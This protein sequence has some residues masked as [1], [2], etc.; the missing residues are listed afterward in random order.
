MYTKN[1]SKSLPSLNKLLMQ[2]WARQ[3]SMIGMMP[4]VSHSPYPRMIAHPSR[5]LSNR[6]GSTRISTTMTLR[7]MTT[8]T[9]KTTSP[10]IANTARRGTSMRIIII[11]VTG[12]LNH[13]FNS[14]KNSKQNKSKL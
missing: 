3:G 5:L 13:R 10:S 2:K 4:P 8:I 6:T 9:R 14:M 1:N 11:S 7:R 12:I